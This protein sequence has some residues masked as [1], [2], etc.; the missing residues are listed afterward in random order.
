MRHINEEFP[1]AVI[2]G[3]RLCQKQ[4]AHRDPH[5]IAN[6]R[7]NLVGVQHQND[8]LISTCTIELQFTFVTPEALIVNLCCSKISLRSAGI[9]S[10]DCSS[11][12]KEGAEAL[13]T[14]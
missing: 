12:N 11:T 6:K 2:V 3:Q 13:R 7:A 1:V 10:S 8:L 9:F 14:V 4:V 5:L